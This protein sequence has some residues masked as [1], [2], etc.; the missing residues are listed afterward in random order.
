MPK[1]VFALFGHFI[2]MG[3][4]LP[5]MPALTMDLYPPEANQGTPVEPI[6]KN[7]TLLIDSG[8]GSCAM[9][10]EKL[11]LSQL[12]PKA[13]TQFHGIGVSGRTEM[14]SLKLQDPSTGVWIRVGAAAVPLPGVAGKYDGLIG[15]DFLSGFELIINKPNG[16]IILNRWEV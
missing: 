2:D 9:N 8:S 6:A 14:Y 7:V 13:S 16:T 11:D 10:S 1:L 12:T 15:M 4:G 3:A 5:E